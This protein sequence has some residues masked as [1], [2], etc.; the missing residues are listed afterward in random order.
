MADDTVARVAGW[1]LIVMRRRVMVIAPI[2]N[3]PYIAAGWC[4]LWI[5]GGKK[6]FH[7]AL[8][9]CDPVEAA[10]AVFFSSLTSFLL[11]HPSTP[12]SSRLVLELPGGRTSDKKAEPDS[13][14]SEET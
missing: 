9:P 2:P 5:F 14:D 10:P 12:C 1:T 6:I 8:Q 3:G 4:R 13:S 11:L 7:A